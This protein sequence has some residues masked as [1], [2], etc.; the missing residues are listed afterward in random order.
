MG[1]ERYMLKSESIKNLSAALSKFQGEVKNPP[2]SANNPFFKS[3]YAPLDVVISTAKP[4]LAKYGLSYVQLP[5]C[6]GEYV[7]CTTVLMLEEEFLESDII[8]IKPS[9]MDVQGMGATITY[10]KRYQLSALLG[11]A[12]EEDKDGEEPSI[13]AKKTDKEENKEE[14]KKIESELVSEIK[15]ETIKKM[16]TETNTNEEQFCE[17]Y[18]IPIVSFMTNSIFIRAM[19]A[20]GKKKETLSKTPKPQLDI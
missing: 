8:K 6:D 16:L 20:L 13:K 7:T 14:I 18:G 3:K 15:I 19:N 1:G 12:S 10:L 11:L 2:N 4:V 17:H 5:G 9:K